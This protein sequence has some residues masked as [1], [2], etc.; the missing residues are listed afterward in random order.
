MS[1]RQLLAV[2]LCATAVTG[3]GIV[4]TSAQ[5]STKGKKE[6]RPSQ[7]AV[8]A[9]NTRVIADRAYGSDPK[10]RLDVYAPTDAK[11]VPVVIFVHG[12]EWTKGD[13]SEVSY[14]PKFFNE[15][16]IVFVSTNYRLSPPAKHPDH[17]SDV[18]SAVRWVRDRAAEFGG[19]ADKIVLMG[20]SA[21]CHLVTLA[22]L[23]PRY[24][25]TVKL[26]PTDVCGVVAWSGGMYDLADRVKGEGL[27]PKYIRQ[28]FG[29]TEAAWRD[30]S[31]AAHVGDAP[32]PAFLFVSIQ[33]GNASHK[34]AESM[35]AAIRKAKGDADTRLLEG[36][37][38]FMANH[39]VGAPGDATGDVLLE[40]IRKVTK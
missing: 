23:D 12:G 21:G 18:A 2:A 39:L 5:E 33:K 27:Y 38:H 19:A 31:P 14:K 7:A 40:F 34:A 13:K 35:A 32:M 3:F 37:T 22:T 36:R 29:D 4:R 8:L 17:V 25:A 1:L 6:E 16:G 15:H 10:Q 24:L 9:K 30:A 11:N 20:H 28:T 26:R